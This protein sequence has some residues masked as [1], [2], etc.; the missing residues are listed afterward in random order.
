MMAA[1]VLVVLIATTAVIVQGLFLRPDQ[2]E[3]FLGRVRR[4]NDKGLLK[5]EE[6]RQGDLEREC[7]EESCSHEEAREVFENVP[8]TRA[9]LCTRFALLV[10]VP[11]S[12][13]RPALQ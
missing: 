7:V 5:L 3:A 12:N 13:R 4:A 2:A 10:K 6:R 9:L 1:G 11:D 8:E